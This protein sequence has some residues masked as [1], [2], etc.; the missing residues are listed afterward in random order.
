MFIYL[1][2]QATRR[3]LRK[4][5][6]TW[7]TIGLTTSLAAEYGSRSIRVNAIVPGYIESKMTEGALR[8]ASECGPAHL[9]LFLST[10]QTQI[11][12]HFLRM[13]RA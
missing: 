4:Y 11:Q 10:A 2:L 1:S 6:S 5:G 13:A 9:F 7:H 3:G 8:S 12:L